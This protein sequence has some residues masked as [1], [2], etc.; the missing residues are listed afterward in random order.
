MFKKDNFK[1]GLVIGVLAPFL[2]MLA[3]YTWKFY[4]QYT[5]GDFFHVLMIQKSLITGILS[6]SLFINAVIFTFFINARSDKTAKGIFI[7][8]CIYAIAALL[9]KWLV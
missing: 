6:F 4:P 1:L 5:L 8:T 9:L 2:G 7:I 3:F